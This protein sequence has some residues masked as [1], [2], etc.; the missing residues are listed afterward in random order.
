LIA[1]EQQDWP[2]WLSEAEGDHAALLRL[3]PVLKGPCL[4]RELREAAAPSTLFCICV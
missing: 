1:A 3:A 4:S 2:V